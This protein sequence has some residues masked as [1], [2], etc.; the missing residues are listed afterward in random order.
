MA[1]ESRPPSDNEINAFGSMLAA[2]IFSSSVLGASLLVVQIVLVL[3]GVSGFFAT[4]KERRKG[5]IRFVIIS[6]LM[7]IMSAVDISFD[8]WDYFLVLYTGGPDGK[9]YLL[10]LRGL[11]EKSLWRCLVLWAD[12]K[13]VVMFPFLACLGSI[14]SNI[15][16][17][18]GSIASEIDL[19]NNMQLAGA[20]LNVTMNIMVTSLILLRVLLARYRAAKV[21][22]DQKPPRW[23]SEV[24]AL[25]VESAAPLAIFGICDIALRG[26]IVAESPS[27]LQSGHVLQRGRRSIG[28]GVIDSF[29]YAFCTL[30]PQMIIVRVTR[31]KAWNSSRVVED[32]GE[33]G[34]ISQP[35][36]FA[37]SESEM[38]AS[39]PSNIS[40]S[41]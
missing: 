36:Q 10:A 35:I 33:G 29:Y 12:K 5:R 1:S 24:T 4:P 34:N 21:F 7:V 15:T 17:M 13:W 39:I 6:A 3:Y 14:A 16:F 8:L 27:Q 31:G 19:A 11:R 20:I 26:T 38:T 41:P 30:S 28:L 40:V 23:Y 2:D 9:S 22:P 37:H 32:T 18:V 25:V